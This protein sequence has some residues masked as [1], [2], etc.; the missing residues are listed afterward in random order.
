MIRHSLILTEGAAPKRFRFATVMALS[1][2]KS[3]K[4]AS[5]T[6]ALATT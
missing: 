4:R 2:A 5:T 1:E 6:Y 3:G